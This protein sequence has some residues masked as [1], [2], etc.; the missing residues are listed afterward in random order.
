MLLVDPHIFADQLPNLKDT[1]VAAGRNLALGGLNS[2][3]VP[4][5]LWTGVADACF[6]AFR[7]QS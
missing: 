4:C 2:G 6:L 1:I 5:A 7:S 3:E